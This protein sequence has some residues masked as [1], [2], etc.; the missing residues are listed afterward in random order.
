MKSRIRLLV[1]CLQFAVLSGCLQTQVIDDISLIQTVSF[2]K[3]D[4]DNI[5]YTVSYPF[6]LEQ[7][8]ESKIGIEQRSIISETPEEA[9]SQLNTK[10][11]KP[12]RYGQ[13]RVVLFGQ[14]IAEEGVEQYARSFYRNPRIGNRIF[15]AVSDGTAG[16]ALRF[17]EGSKER[18]GMYFS[19]MI[20]HNMNF[21]NIP[22]S[23]MHLFLFNLYNDGK[24]AFL[25]M[26]KR[27]KQEL[28][29]TGVGLFDGERM[30]A[31][32]NMKE[33]FILKL[34]LSGSRNG[35]SQFPISEQGNKVYVVIENI[36]TDLDFRDI[37]KTAQQPAYEVNLD[38][39]GEV[40]DHT[41]DFNLSN[42]KDIGTIESKVQKQIK[43][44]AA[45]LIQ[46]FQDT[47]IDPLGFGEKYRS[48]TRNWNP[49]KWKESMYPKMD[50]Q[51]KVNLEILQSGAI[52]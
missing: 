2:D 27:E 18:I 22:E 20:E 7:G 39:K 42:K 4:D 8:K 24:D 5:H 47:N 16:N 52:E 49:E 32:L 28:H 50:V 48:T 46:R 31:S 14:D 3:E 21:E 33:T 45:D 36:F 51:V 17:E 29:L 6:F 25:P 23:N 44:E 13:L 9:R 12:L 35:T 30:T 1:V 34:L 19:N 15:L 43:T 38:M 11:D 41:G 37:S 10:T 40:T 26:V